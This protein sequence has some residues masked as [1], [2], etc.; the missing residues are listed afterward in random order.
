MGAHPSKGPKITD[1]DRAVLELKRQRDRVRQYQVKLQHVLDREHELARQALREGNKDRA[2]LALRRRAY[3]QG[4]IDKTDQQLATL[5]ELVSTIEFAQLEQSIVYG[6][7]Q[8]N[9][10][11][12][13]IHKET[14]LERVERL[15]DTTAEAQQYQRDVDD[16][17]SSHL[18]VEEQEEVEE[19]LAALSQVV[20]DTQATPAVQSLPN[21]PTSEL[22]GPQL[23]TPMPE[24]S[25]VADLS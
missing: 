19:E 9:E 20:P 17:L 5:Q 6:L 2:R 22:V 4:L 24:R 7:E 21:A 16:M 13:Q 18:S 12:K 11:L 23:K 25:M 10:V 14:S 3:Q 1:Q 8:G 15:M